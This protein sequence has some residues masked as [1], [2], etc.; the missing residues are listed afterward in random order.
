M[1]N[2]VAYNKKKRVEVYAKRYVL[3]LNQNIHD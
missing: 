1:K 2:S 3:M